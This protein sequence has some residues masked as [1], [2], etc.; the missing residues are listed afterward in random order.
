MTRAEFC[1]WNDRGNRT[2]R[3]SRS[4]EGR[5][6]CFGAFGDARSTVS[7]L[8]ALLTSRVPSSPPKKMQR[9]EGAGG[10]P[11]PR[12]QRARLSPVWHS[13]REASERHLRQ[14]PSLTSERGD[15]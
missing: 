10:A 13:C 2:I 1:D 12:A 6:G 14:P 8:R 9:R 7:V 15:N 5:R 4:G 3:A 11:P